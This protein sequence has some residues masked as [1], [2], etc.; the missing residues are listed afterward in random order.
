MKVAVA[1]SGGVDSSVAAALMVR[2]YG[3]ESVFGVTAK[4]FCYAKESKNEKACCSLDAINDAKAVCDK[5]GIAHYVISEEEEFKRAVINKFIEAY[6]LGQTPIPCI[7]CNNAIKFGTMLKHVKK[8]GADKLVT[9]HYARVQPLQVKSKK[10]K[11]KSNKNDSISTAFSYNLLRGVDELKDQTYFLHGLNQEQLSQIDFPVGGMAKA[12]VRAI[13]K[14]IG[15]RTAE[16]RESQGV[17]FV[18]EGTVADWLSDK[19]DRKPGKIVD[20]QGNTIGEHEGIAYYTVGQRKKIGGGHTKP[21]FVIG[22]DAT[23]NEV[24]VGGKEHLYKK[25]LEISNVHWINDVTLPLKCTAKIRYNMKDEPCFVK[26]R[27]SNSKSQI[28]NWKLKI[29][30]CSVVFSKP[31]RAITPGQSVVFYKGAKCLGGGIIVR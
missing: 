26:L 17:C 31:Q 6:R 9:G 13:A 8:L 3:P 22:I 24:I 18:T 20:I 25:G 21:M 23:R 28:E 4:L 2:K 16:K 29:G 1:M 15:L 10:L 12:R 14:R 19:I 30:N 5:L 11:V 27:A 7:P